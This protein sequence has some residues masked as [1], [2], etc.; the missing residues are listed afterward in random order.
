MLRP[1]FT[2]CDTFISPTMNLVL[3]LVKKIISCMMM[4]VAISVRLDEIGS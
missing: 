3:S 1:R 4:F 2:V